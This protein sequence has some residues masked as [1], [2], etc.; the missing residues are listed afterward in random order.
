MGKHDALKRFGRPDYDT[1]VKDIEIL[2]WDYAGD[3]LFQEKK[4]APK[5]RIAK[6][7]FGYH[8]SMLFRENKLAALILENDIP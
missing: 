2:E 6:N 3:I 8:L 7:S 1:L 4:L 5:G